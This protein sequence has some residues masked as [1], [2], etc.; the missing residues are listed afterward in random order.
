VP[1]FAQDTEKSYLESLLESTLSSDN[2]KVSVTGLKGALSSSAK[3]ARIDFSDSNGVWLSIEKAAL[4]WTRSALI[5]KR[6]KIKTLT[7]DKITIFRKPAANEDAISPK[8]GVFRA[9]ELPVSVSIQT[10]SAKELILEDKVFG[11][12]ARLQLTGS[13]EIAGGTMNVSMQAQDLDNAGEFELKTAINIEDKAVLVHLKAK[14]AAN[15]LI[16][17]LLDIPG[18]PSLF[19]AIDGGG[20]N[21]ALITDIHLETNGSDRLDGKVIISPKIIDDKTDGVQIAVDLT[22]DLAP[23]LKSEYQA[24]FGDHSTLKAVAQLRK[25]GEIIIS[26]LDVQTAALTVKGHLALAADRTPTRI[27]LVS[28][29][30]NVNDAPVLLPLTGKETYVKSAKLI[31]KYNANEP[32][33][34]AFQIWDLSRGDLFVEGLRL[35]GSGEIPEVFSTISASDIFFTANLD[36]SATS[37]SHNN[38]DLD[39]AIGADMRASGK[40]T[41]NKDKIVVI[42]DLVFSDGNITAGFD[43]KVEGLDSALDITGELSAQIN[44]LSA[45]SKIVD[46]DIQGET[47]LNAKGRIALLTGAFDL[48]IQTTGRSLSLGN[49]AID[50]F[51]TGEN[52]A[53]VSMIRTRDGLLIEKLTLSSPQLSVNASGK[54]Q[55]DQVSAD[56]TAEIN[57][58]GVISDTLSGPL[59]AIGSLKQNGNTIS[60]DFKTTGADGLK[61]DITGA[62]PID[63]GIWN[64][65]MKGLAPLAFADS[66]LASSSIRARGNVLFDLGLNGQP[67]LVNVFGK[68]STKGARIDIPALQVLVQDIAANVDLADG[69][70]NTRVSANLSTGGQINGDGQISLNP[71]QDFPVDLKIQLKNIT[72]E[73]PSLYKTTINGNLALS[74]PAL[75]GPTL[76]GQIDILETE[77]NIQ[78][79][80]GPNSSDIPDIAHK[81][82]PSASRMTRERAGM[83]V[84]ETQ[85]TDSNRP[86]LLDLIINAPSRIFIRGRGLNAELGGRVQLTGTTQS[87]VPVGS[88]DLIR[89]RLVILSKQLALTEGKISMAGALDPT[90][91]VVATSSSDGYETSVVIS[92]LLSNP[93]FTFESSPELPEDEIL[94]Q[95]LFGSQLDQISPFQA[96]QLAA[97][98]RELTGKGRGGGFGLR[99]KLS[100]DDLSIGTDS[101]GTTGLRAG[102]YISDK[103]YT[104]VNIA[105]DGESE[106]S[107]HLDLNTNLSVKASVDEEGGSKFG[108]LYKKDY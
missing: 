23:L 64:L 100:L 65:K 94:A 29:L 99:S 62:V 74:G 98:I 25:N 104:D 50:P 55:N 31:L 88:I 24:F 16:V 61:A 41:L 6:V 54:M 8:A 90:I 44:D 2:M 28:R 81:N 58:L 47:T 5:Q 69:T 92:G 17:N 32:W 97:A 60:V 75:S 70:A 79:A 35:N 106:V 67:S 89:G 48:N 18:K 21:T 45:V 34:G 40:V 42:S 86:I 103:V 36:A 78:G 49:S 57:D 14:E 76:R 71:A 15:G 53:A 39:H 27:N 33:F 68:I 3:I 26:G 107:I 20:T 56:L 101:D 95:M 105:G 82:E 13:I 9:P 85:S 37:V 11:Y 46:Q 43:G 73:N 102:K 87:V 96:L 4:N 84:A 7:A 51:I 91:R 10:I 22:G 83:I 1:V 93:E 66:L 108:F 59:K 72:R 30:E 52:M 19:V 80:L 12:A 63:D 38:A 77:I